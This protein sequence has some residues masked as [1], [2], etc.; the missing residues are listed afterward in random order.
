MKS[1]CFHLFHKHS[2]NT[3]AEQLAVPVLILSLYAYCDPVKTQRR[4]RSS[5]C[6]CCTHNIKLLHQ[7]EERAATGLHVFHSFTGRQQ[8]SKGSE[9]GRE[10]PTDL[11]RAVEH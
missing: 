6:R 11:I 3:P 10:V 5:T 1:I 2:V 7:S 4:S 8:F 9:R